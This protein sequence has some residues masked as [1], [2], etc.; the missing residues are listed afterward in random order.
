[1]QDE[2]LE[3][4][5]IIYFE[6][7]SLEVEKYTYDSIKIGMHS[8]IEQILDIKTST[9]RLITYI[10]KIWAIEEKWVEKEENNG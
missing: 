1:M 8:D 10:S 6:N 2:K 5:Y 4:K 3:L 7:Q 9:G